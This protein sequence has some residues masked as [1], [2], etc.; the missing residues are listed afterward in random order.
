[1]RD[2]PPVGCAPDHPPHYQTNETPQPPETATD[3]H[4]D[5]ETRWKHRRRLAY[6][7]FIIG[8]TCVLLAICLVAFSLVTGASLEVLM[9]L[10]IW[11]ALGNFGLTGAYMGLATLYPDTNI[12][13]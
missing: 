2:Y 10:L 7:A 4:P 8:N 11:C 9:P 12:T 3:Q 5:P 1:M 13:R 6:T